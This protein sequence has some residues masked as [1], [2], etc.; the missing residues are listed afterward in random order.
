VNAT[1]IPVALVVIPIIAVIVLVGA[2]IV[3]T[4]L[5]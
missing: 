2:F 4:V 5:S 1:H 3:G